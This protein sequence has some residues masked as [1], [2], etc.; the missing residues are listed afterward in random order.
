MKL[1]TA[2]A[3]A[4]MLLLGAQGTVHAAV[5]S[6]SV[7]SATELGEFDHRAYREVELRLVGTAPGGAYDVPVT[8]AYPTDDR[9]YSGVAVVDVVGTAFMLFPGVLPAPATPDPLYLARLQLGDDYLFGSGHVYMS[10]IWDKDALALAGTGT[11]AERGDGFSI[12]R[13][14]AGLAR[15]PSRIPAQERPNASGT[16]IAYGQSQT[17][18]LLRN[19]YRQHANSSGGLA[20]DG[21]L[22]VSARGSCADPALGSL[23]NFRCG[24]GPVSDGG[25]VIALSSETDA[26]WFGYTERGQT[27]D[28]RLMEIAGTA[29]IPYSAFA[30]V[31]APAQNPASWTPVARASM[32]NLVAWIG[33][34]TP[35]DSNYITLEEDVGELL[36]LPFREAIRDA[37]G[38]AVGGVRLPHMT[39]TDKRHE[40]GAPLGTYDGVEFDTGNIFILLAGHFTPFDPARLEALY[41][42]HGTYVRRV[43]KAAHR[44]VERRELLK[45]DAK[46]F[47][48]EAAHSS[49]GK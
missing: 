22:Y 20:F 11:I 28:Y 5:T 8:L 49:V 25:K 4:F 48:K 17:A 19:F 2:S 12:I 29:H 30:F 27:A 44:L 21:A 18:R 26:E 46:A 39:A 34:T 35:P 43:T 16:I 13:D 40:I 31:D 1:M 32:S 23:S 3:I 41:P 47:I 38:N 42:S 6:V 15:D 24:D 14:V 9:D 37:D 45:E 7:V 36:G 10:V 33:G